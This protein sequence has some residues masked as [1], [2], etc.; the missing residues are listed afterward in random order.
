MWITIETNQILYPD[1]NFELP[2]WLNNTNFIE[3]KEMGVE[4]SDISAVYGHDEYFAGLFQTYV[5]FKSGKVTIVVNTSELEA[6]QF[7]KEITDLK[8]N[9]YT[10]RE[11]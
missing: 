8:V 2:S 9:E 10:K 3:T 6:L 11:V 5:E 4:L 7:I 1:E